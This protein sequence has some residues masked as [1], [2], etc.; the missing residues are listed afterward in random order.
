[1]LML[2]LGTSASRKISVSTFRASVTSSGC[3]FS[4]SFRCVAFCFTPYASAATVRPARSALR[5]VV[6]AAP[7]VRS[8]VVFRRRLPL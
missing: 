2:P 4:S 7:A 6:R 1:M 5:A 8:T 3:G